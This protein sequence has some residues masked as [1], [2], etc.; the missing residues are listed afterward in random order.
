MAWHGS[1]LRTGFEKKERWAGQGY[2]SIEERLVC[3]KRNRLLTITQ[4]RAGFS[5]FYI[6]LHIIF[7]Y[8]WPPSQ[9]LWVFKRQQSLQVTPTLGQR[10]TGP[11]S[12]STYLVE[13]DFKSCFGLPILLSSNQA[14]IH[15]NIAHLAEAFRVKEELSWVYRKQQNRFPEHSAVLP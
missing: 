14:N 12:L 8:V 1:F 6:A 7:N 5:C 13:K 4:N 11:R 10:W 15:V 3:L 2:E 9:L